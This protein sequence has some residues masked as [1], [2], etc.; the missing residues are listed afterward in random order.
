MINNI[1]QV[2]PGNRVDFSK[3]RKAQ[4]G[5][6][7]PKFQSP[8]KPIYNFDEFLNNLPTNRFQRAQT[9]S[10]IPWTPNWKGVSGKYANVGELEANE[11]YKAFTDYVIQNA[12]GDNA[13][14]RVLEYL[15]LLER[16]TID[17]NHKAI[18]FDGNGNLNQNWANEY[19]R[20]RNDGKY[21]YYH[22]G[23]E[24][25]P[26]TPPQTPPETPPET[27][28]TTPPSGPSEKITPPG[29]YTPDD[30]YK[31]FKFKPEPFLT[32][33]PFI[34]GLSLAANKHQYDNEMQKKV[35]LLEAPYLQGVVTNN[36]AARQIRNQ[37][38]ANARSRAQQ[39]LGSDQIQNQQYLQAVEQNLQPLENQNAIDQTQEFNETFQRLKDIQNQNKLAW[40]QVANQNRA[41]LIADWN[42]R[43]DAK[44]K[45][46]WT[47]N[48]IKSDFINK[49]WTDFQQWAANEKNERD[50]ALASYNDYI[51]NIG[52]QNA[53]K[54]YTDLASDPMKSR[55]F[56]T[57]YQNALNDFNSNLSNNSWLTSNK[58]LVDI[59]ANDDL[60]QKAKN[61]AFM[62]YLRTSNSDYTTQFNQGYN[63]ELIEAKNKAITDRQ[64]I[65]NELASI[66]P[67]FRNT[68]IGGWGPW[69]TRRLGKKL[70]LFSKDGGILKM[71][72]GSRFVDYLEHNRKAIKDQK[73]TTIE[74]SKQMERQ[75]KEQLQAL[76]RETLILLR[77][78]FK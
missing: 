70:T 40:A 37:Q 75:L 57:V 63:S 25:E 56:A 45:Y 76:D 27:P 42:R 64:S 33:N 13:D 73:Q 8:A 39:Q 65:Q 58:S 4:Q 28:P 52:I 20:L 43:L 53:M 3:I 47:R 21:G 67:S 10:S 41:N 59:F 44:S 77:S 16:T 61:D 6:I 1:T 12:Q 36:Y 24:G 31:D 72:H 30:Y 32:P 5:M 68:Y 55:S 26:E 49:T 74:V 50:S 2:S 51:A 11:K 35:P 23:P 29:D 19:R 46:Q 60:D 18:L 69:D 9:K 62:N 48:N 34:A 38:M 22:L 7:I 17:P 71:K 15:K 14:P 66:Q 78:I 54:P